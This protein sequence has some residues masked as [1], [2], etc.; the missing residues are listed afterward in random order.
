MA[1]MALR[2]IPAVQTARFLGAL[3]AC[4]WL[5]GGVHAKDSAA[6]KM[7]VD[8]TTEP[9]G[10]EVYVGD[11]LFAGYRFDDGGKPIV[12]PVYGPDGLAMTRNFPMKKDIK[13]E[14]SDHD[15]HR[16]LWLTHGDV[17]GVDFWLDDEGCGRIVHQDGS[18]KVTD[19]GTVVLLTSNHWLGPDGNK[20]LGDTRRFEFI[21]DDDRRIIDCDVLLKA[22][23]GDVNFGDTKEG[24]FGIRVAGTMKVD[25]RTGGKITNAEGL[26][27]KEA[28]GKPSPWVDYSGPVQDKVGGITIHAHPSGFGAPCR[29]HVRTY[30]LFAA[31][32][33]GVHHFD[34]G[35]KR[36]GIVLKEGSRMRLNYRVVLHRGEL[37]FDVANADAEKYAND[38]RP[39]ME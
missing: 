2:R 5:A 27:N 20:I 28:W 30:G 17:N 37:D 7:R 8:A 21:V 39:E 16:S 26:T 29:W 6:A 36:G 33:F 25:A 11:Q 31:N 13:G 1:A 19:D 32:P 3:V 23:D 34:G 4:G 10:W 18:A 35:P 12:Y 24:T 15:H 9:A 14:R 22:T 38:P